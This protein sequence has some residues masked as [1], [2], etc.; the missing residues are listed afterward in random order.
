MMTGLGVRFVLLHCV[1]SVSVISL[2]DSPPEWSEV[3]GLCLLAIAVHFLSYCNAMCFATFRS[4]LLA[5]YIYIY[6]Y[7]Y[8][9]GGRERSVS[10][11]LEAHYN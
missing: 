8:M 5:I 9:G 11:S 10:E 7:I 6:I 3:N 4:R 1:P 2:S